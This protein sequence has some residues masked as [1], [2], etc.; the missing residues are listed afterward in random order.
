[1]PQTGEWIWVQWQKILMGSCLST[2]QET[3]RPHS[4]KTFSAYSLDSSS[5]LINTYGT[6]MKQYRSKKSHSFDRSP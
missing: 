2:R 3:K 4:P 6:E 1:M 5:Q